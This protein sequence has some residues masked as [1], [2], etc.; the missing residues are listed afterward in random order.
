MFPCRISSR[1]PTSPSTSI[2]RRAAAVTLRRDLPVKALSWQKNK[3]DPVFLSQMRPAATQSVPQLNIHS[4]HVWSA[5]AFKILELTERSSFC[6]LV[7]ADSFCKHLI[8][9]MQQT[10]TSALINDSAREASGSSASRHDGCLR[11]SPL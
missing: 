4:S 3:S 2:N 10:Q 6:F 7:D 11:S 5:E 8:I 1:A 9:S